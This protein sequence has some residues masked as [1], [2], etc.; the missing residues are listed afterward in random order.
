MICW[1]HIFLSFALS[2]TGTLELIVKQS[3]KQSLRQSLKCKFSTNCTS[4]HKI[5]FKIPGQI[6]YKFQDIHYKLH[7]IYY[8]FHILQ[9]PGH[10]YYKF[11]DFFF[12]DF[13]TW[14][15]S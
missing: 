11:L 3:L 10:I 12:L 14:I 13:W 1:L 7:D 6:Y 9:I 5:G 8:K 15:V 2:V 4:D